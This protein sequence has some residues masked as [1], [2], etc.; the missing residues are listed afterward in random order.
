VS[1]VTSKL[2]ASGRP[3]S[4]T[5]LLMDGLPP[6]PHMSGDAYPHSQ[7]GG[8][9]KGKQARAEQEYHPAEQAAEASTSSASSIST[10][11]GRAGARSRQHLALP[12]GM[13]QLAAH[14]DQDQEKASDDEVAEERLDAE[15][16]AFDAVRKAVARE[17]QAAPPVYDDDDDADDAVDVVE[18]DF[19]SSDG[20]E[21]GAQQEHGEDKQGAQRDEAGRA[22]LVIQC[23]ARGRQAREQRRRLERAAA[24]MAREAMAVTVQVA[25]RGWLAR[26]RYRAEVLDAQD[27]A[28]VLDAA[29][30]PLRPPAAAALTSQASPAVGTLGGALGVPGGLRPVGAPTVRMLGWT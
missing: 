8:Q 29:A 9:G 24:N 3:P 4:R 2:H 1:R 18:D 12:F 20:D 5:L 22:A 6:P 17:R 30:P 16:E 19:E 27:R 28:E 14:E 11:T 13:P 15:E 26:R 25:V 23:S 10:E 7:T 21:R